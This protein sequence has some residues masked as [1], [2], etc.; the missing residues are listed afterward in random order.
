LKC[1]FVAFGGYQFLTFFVKLLFGRHPWLV[2][3]VT[4]CAE[5]E[6]TRPATSE[7]REP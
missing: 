6:K 5:A 2:A 1:R 3:T 7:R 4:A